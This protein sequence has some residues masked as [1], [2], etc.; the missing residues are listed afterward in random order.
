MKK[1]IFRCKSER[2]NAIN[3]LVSFASKNTARGKFVV[4]SLSR[5]G[6]KLRQKGLRVTGQWDK[7]GR[8]AY[9]YYSDQSSGLMPLMGL[10]KH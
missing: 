3:R 8:T 2:R 9:R 5:N 7:E 4:G 1:I 6:G 10:H